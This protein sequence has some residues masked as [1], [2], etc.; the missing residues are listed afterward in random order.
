[1]ASRDRLRVAL[2]S[3]NFGEY[4]IRLASALAQRAEVLLII[5]DRMVEPFVA[6]LSNSVRLFSFTNPRLR[7]LPASV[8]ARFY[9][10]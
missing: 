3:Y 8:S 1:M 9:N 10:S 2:I 5:P 4:C 7:A 6:K